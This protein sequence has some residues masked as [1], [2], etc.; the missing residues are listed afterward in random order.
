MQYTFTYRSHK[1]ITVLVLHAK[2]A[3]ITLS[4]KFR[5]GKQ[6]SSKYLTNIKMQVK[7]SYK[8][9]GYNLTI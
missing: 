8:Y 7:N 3:Y 4:R 5:I 9:S 6:H 1:Q 2:T